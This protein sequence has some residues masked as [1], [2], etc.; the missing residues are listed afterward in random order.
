VDLVKVDLH[1]LCALMLHGIG[2]EV[3]RI[4]IVAVDEGGTL[5]GAMELLE[6]PTEP[7]G[8]GHDVG[9]SAALNLSAE[10]RD[11]GLSHDDPGDEVGS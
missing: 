5:E 6:K 4:D 3:D 8:I 1:V 10:A 2:G 9:H 7:G 11:N